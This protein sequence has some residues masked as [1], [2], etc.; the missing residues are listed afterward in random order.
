MFK[1][2]FTAIGGATRELLRDWGALAVLAALYGALL[3]AVYWFF[4]TGVATAGQLA[5][6]AL[7]AG[8]APLLF[9]LLQAA[10]ANHAAGAERAREVLL[11]AL[12]DFWKILLV[13]LPLIALAV[14][15]YYLLNKLQARFPVT[16]E[17]AA[18][19]VPPGAGPRA[20]PPPLP[21]R[22]QDVTF[23]ALRLLLLGVVLP[24][25]GIHLWLAVARDGLVAALRNAH[26]WLARA[27][28]PRAVLVYAVGLFLFG[29]MPYFVV[30]T[31]TPV[32]N[33]WGELILF[34]L[35]L[36]LAFL[37]TLCGWAV[38]LGALAKLAPGG[39]VSTAGEAPPVAD[40]PRDE[41]PAQPSTA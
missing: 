22:W 6:S 25:A 1:D 15:V 18:R 34:G 8:F 2:A 7:L 10:T 14:L 11:R 3:F 17:D 5:L 32:K 27:Y 4:A 33:G 40:P 20:A 29:F 9:F 35:R 12:S 24:L 23:S 26:R 41:V 39:E 38:T 21:L 28:A 16:A 30:Y 19:F 37:L 31:T 13:S 36:A